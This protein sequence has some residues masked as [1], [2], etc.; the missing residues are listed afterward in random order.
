MHSRIAS[1]TTA[2]SFKPRKHR[3][4]SDSEEAQLKDES[5]FDE[6]DEDV[7]NF[8]QAPRKVKPS[9]R[10]SLRALLSKPYTF[11]GEETGELIQV[12]A[13]LARMRSARSEEKGLGDPCRERPRLHLHHIWPRRKPHRLSGWALRKSLPSPGP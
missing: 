8:L 2:R 10:A 13:T 4:G 12:I 5:D 6:Y 9:D 3:L 1:R 11:N 7:S